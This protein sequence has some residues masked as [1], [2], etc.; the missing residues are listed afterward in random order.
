[1]ITADAVLPGF[2]AFAVPLEMDRIADFSASVLLV[3][4]NEAGAV[5]AE[6]GDVVQFK[7]PGTASSTAALITGLAAAA[8]IADGG[9]TFAGHHWCRD[10][11]RCEAATL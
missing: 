6:R 2:L 3:L 11:A 5:V 9:V 7:A 8:L 4:A 10:H 1:V